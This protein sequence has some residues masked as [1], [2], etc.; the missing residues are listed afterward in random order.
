MAGTLLL[1]AP[2]SARERLR[3][4]H[5]RARELLR[6]LRAYG[7]A[8]SAGALASRVSAQAL[9]DTGAARRF[10]RQYAWGVEGLFLQALQEAG[11]GP[12]AQGRALALLEWQAE[13][14]LGPMEANVRQLLGHNAA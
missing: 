9:S 12:R 11:A 8:L 1:P 6:L 10:L 3:Q 13:R 7:A 4:R 2:P 14:A 5:R